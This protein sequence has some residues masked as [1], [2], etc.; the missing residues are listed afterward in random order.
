MVG[1]LTRR[2]EESREI[3]LGLRELW[4]G[5]LGER[6]DS[7]LINA[8]EVGRPTP[9]GY[10]SASDAHF[11]TLLDPLVSEAS[12]TNAEEAKR[13][14]VWPQASR[15]ETQG[16]KRAPASARL[17]AYRECESMVAESRHQRHRLVVASLPTG[18]ALRLRLEFLELCLPGLRS[19]IQGSKAEG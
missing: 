10:C 6:C 5:L 14:A 2:L 19:D 15:S 9:G 16:R 11:P 17:E 3:K 12:F 13:D 4:D 1:L 18:A 8:G 7:S